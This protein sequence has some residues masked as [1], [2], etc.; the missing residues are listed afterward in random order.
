VAYDPLHKGFGGVVYRTLIGLHT[1]SSALED[2]AGG[3]WWDFYVG[4]LPFLVDPGV[5]RPY[6]RES[7]PP[8]RE[9]VDQERDPGE[10]SLDSATWLRSATS[11]HL[12][13]GQQV[14]E[15]LESSADIARFRFHAS[16]GVDP[17]TRGQLSL[18]PAMDQ[19]A[20]G[21]R[22][23]LGVAGQ[24]VLVSHNTAGVKLYPSS[25]SA[26]ALSTKTVTQ[27]AANSTYWYA[28]SS[29][30]LE[31][32]LLATGGEGGQALSGATAIHWGLDRLWV[33]AGK[34]L[35]EVTTTAPPP[36]FGAA[37]ES[38][39]DGSIVS[40]ASSG[41]ALYL[42]VNEAMSRVYEIT[43]NDDATLNSPRLV[44]TLPRGETGNFL[45]GYLGR[46][47]VVGTDKGVRVADC[48]T[49]NQLAMGPLVVE[50][51]GGCVDATGSESFLWVTSG[52]D[53]VLP[54]PDGSASPGLWRL[55]LGSQVESVAAYGDTAAARY[56]YAADVWANTS[57]QVWSVTVFAGSLFMVAGSSSSDSPLW[58]QSSSLVTSG[59]V[60]SGRVSYSTA[61]RKA[62]LS[63]G[64]DVAGDG[65]VLVEA[66]TGLGFS[67]VTMSAVGVPYAGTVDVDED[68]HGPSSWMEWRLRLTGDGTVAGSPTVEAVVLRSVPSPRRTRRLMLPLLCKDWQS[69]RHGTTV[70]YD[71]FAWDR[72]RDLEQLELV[73][74][75][76]TVRDRRTGE[77]VRCQIER[78]TFE[79]RTAPD[80]G[81]TNF[82]GRLQLV[83][84]VV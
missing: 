20:T 66:D 61:E 24:G 21:A 25:G 57:G 15:P 22:R 76:V 49:P 68:V 45:Y 5:E 80:R 34:D 18:L 29:S 19:R 82:G 43:V 39:R 28:L 42:L 4:P 48:G 16:G 7:T 46:Y 44:D 77:Q 47:L 64:L 41:A 79:G 32:G 36:A 54:D 12:G 27:L 67:G 72:V 14:A 83:L 23:C 8:R 50:M 81:C 3:P 1:T 40:I 53:G 73:G 78:V 70:G 37:T 65:T 69:D 56:A 13:A 51:A 26:T 11:W 63:V 55:S 17:W 60:S 52:S 35:H 71:G 10:A 33:A 62:W 84:L 58:Q 2:D 74:N 6:L 75:L 59:W 30:G 31:Y 38:F 9:R